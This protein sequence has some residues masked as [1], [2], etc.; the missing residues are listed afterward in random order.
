MSSTN[1][2]SPGHRQQPVLLIV[3]DDE[4][5]LSS[6]SRA[7]SD[8]F[9]V[10]EASSPEA[11]AAGFRREP[12]LVLLDIRF[13]RESDGDRVGIRLLEEFLAARAATPIVM[14]SAY[15]DV[16]TAVECMRLG[17]A[18]FVKKPINITEIRQRLL[19]AVEHTK[20]LRRAAG[21]EERLQQIDPAELVGESPQMEEV[22]RLIGMVA[23]DGYATVLITGETGTG[24]ELVAKAIHKVGWRSDE[25]FVPVAVSSFNPSLVESELFG[26]EPGAFTG[27][28]ERRI[29]FLEKAKGGVLFLDEVGDL[30]EPTQLK[31]LRFLEERTFARAGSSQELRLDVQV[32]AATNRNLEEAVAGGHIR[33]DFYYRLK[34]VQLNLPPL[35]ER[36]ADIPVLARHFLDV[37]RRQGRTRV[38]SIQI[39]A[40][41]ALARYDWPGNVRELRAA[42]ERAVI[43]ANQHGHG[44]IEK[45]DLPLDVLQPR[46]DGAILQTEP[47]ITGQLVDL[48]EKLARVELGYIEAALRAADGRKAEAWKLLG[49]N[50]RFALRRRVKLLLDR[51]PEL[52]AGFPTVRELYCL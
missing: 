35:R 31:L 26:H 50:D 5:L 9:D 14:M 25:P 27:A 10:L 20:V 33:K 21:L 30:P 8:D 37:L 13:E 19:G 39:A 52:A 18:D 11:A 16:E 29:G 22:K 1:R 32:V 28:K 47:R 7:L 34:S 38:D 36:T 17:A 45:D 12:D 44:R 24:K 23:E 3:D 41:E 40:M 4:S 48:E 51:H 6:L 49:L 2:Q 43:Y 42:I 15:G 46:V